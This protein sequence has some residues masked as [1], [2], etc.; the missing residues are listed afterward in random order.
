MAAILGLIIKDVNW[1]FYVLFTTT[2][3]VF[4]KSDVLLFLHHQDTVSK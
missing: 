2:D 1:T 3:V 4:H